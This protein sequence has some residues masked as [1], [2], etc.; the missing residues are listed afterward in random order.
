MIIGVR[1][2]GPHFPRHFSIDDHRVWAA[3]GRFLTATLGGEG[4]AEDRGKGRGSGLGDGAGGDDG[5]R[6][7]NSAPSCEV[8]S[9]HESISIG[10]TLRIQRSW[11]SAEATLPNE[12]VISV[13]VRI[14]V[15]T[16]VNVGCDWSDVG[17]GRAK[18]KLIQGE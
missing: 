17:V 7:V 11:A 18:S 2:V 3:T 9:V 1:Q 8:S 12:E 15:E 10:V 14:C 5:L 4:E 16:G 6:A 13:N